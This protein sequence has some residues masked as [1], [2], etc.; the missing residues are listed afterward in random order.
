[1]RNI[2]TVTG[3]APSSKR[4]L[5]STVSTLAVAALVLVLA[6]LPAEYGVDLTGL[7]QRMGLTALHQPTDS[8]STANLEVVAPV[9]TLQ[10]KAEKWRSDSVNLTLPA[11]QG[12][13][14]KAQMEAGETLLFQ[15]EASGGTVSFDMHGNVINAAE[16]DFTSY[17]LGKEETQAAGTFTAPFSGLHGWYWENETNQTVNITLT[18]EGYYQG[19]VS[20]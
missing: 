16:D 15:W 9:T 4:L 17:W 11:K 18:T 1:M 3:E 20:H 7:G 12:L 13:E 2:S 8:K 14:V 5:L 10:K 6:V 19:L